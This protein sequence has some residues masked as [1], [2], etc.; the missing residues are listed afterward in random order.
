MRYVWVPLSFEFVVLVSA[1]LIPS[2]IWSLSISSGIFSLIVFSNKLRFF[3]D[4]D[5]NFLLFLFHSLVLQFFKDFRY[6]TPSNE[7]GCATADNE[8]RSTLREVAEACF[9]ARRRYT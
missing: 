9:K 4:R 5:S 3:I 6:C 8:P 7:L 2:R 1:A